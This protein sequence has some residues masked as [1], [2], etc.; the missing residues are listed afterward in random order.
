[1][2]ALSG[3]FAT[4]FGRFLAMLPDKPRADEPRAGGLKWPALC[5][6]GLAGLAFITPL[7]KWFVDVLVLAIGVVFVVSAFL[8]LRTTAPD[9]DPISVPK[10]LLERGYSGDVMAARLIDSARDTLYPGAQLTGIMRPCAFAAEE[11]EFDK[12]IAEYRKALDLFPNYDNAKKNLDA[13]NR[14]ERPTLPP[15][16]GSPPQR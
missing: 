3:E 9:M 12:A 15:A 13:A 8:E 10:S 16:A 1:M 5:R 4:P 14:K 11:G 6:V 7:R 2:P